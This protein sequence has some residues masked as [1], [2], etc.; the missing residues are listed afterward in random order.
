MTVRPVDENKQ[1]GFSNSRG[2]MDGVREILGWSN[3][4]VASVLSKRKLVEVATIR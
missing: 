1:N 2:E 3:R 4:L